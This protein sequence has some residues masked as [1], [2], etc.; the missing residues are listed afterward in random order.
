MMNYVQTPVFWNLMLLMLVF[1][2]VVAYG[3][4]INN[5]FNF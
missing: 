3:M 4:F 2:L 1:V 5:N